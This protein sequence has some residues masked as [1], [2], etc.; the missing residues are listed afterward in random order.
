[1]NYGNAICAFCVPA[2]DGGSIKE[3]D[4][5]RKKDFMAKHEIFTAY[6]AILVY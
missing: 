4:R 1:M 3:Q 6:F 2:C 5:S